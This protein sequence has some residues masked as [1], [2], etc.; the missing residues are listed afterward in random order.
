[1]GLLFHTSC[2]VND[3]ARAAAFYDELLRTIGASRI[4]DQMPLAVGYGLAEEGPS[5]WLQSPAHFP[6]LKTASHCHFAFKVGTSKQ[7]MAFH[8]KAIALGAETVFDSREQSNM[9][10][11]LGFVFK[12]LDGHL[13]EV[14]MLQEV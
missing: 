11:Y 6:F 8:D 13:P 10:G 4:V 12:D 1:M 9:P 7:V 2:V 5:F 14:F 3:I